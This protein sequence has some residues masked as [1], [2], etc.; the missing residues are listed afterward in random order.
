MGGWYQNSTFTEDIIHESHGFWSDLVNGNVDSNSI[1]Y[2]QTSQTNISKSYISASTTESQF[3]IPKAN[4]LP[5]K[6]KPQKYNSW[7]YLLGKSELIEV[8]EKAESS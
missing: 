8:P 7:Y 1:N 3:E 4:E 6:A 2:N 5:A